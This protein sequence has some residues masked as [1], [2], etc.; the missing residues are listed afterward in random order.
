MPGPQP[1]PILESKSVVLWCHHVFSLRTPAS[2]AQLMR[3]AALAGASGGVVSAILGLVSD[4]LRR[5]FVEPINCPTI[6]DIFHPPIY[7]TLDYPS[8]F[9]GILIGLLL[10]P[11]LETLVLLRQLWALQVR[12][13]FR[14]QGVA[15][16]GYRVLE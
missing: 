2:L 10:G 3:P 14:V 6:Q 7:W 12:A 16:A 9:L 8:L 5:D 1:D 13:R 11:I 4:S 15:R